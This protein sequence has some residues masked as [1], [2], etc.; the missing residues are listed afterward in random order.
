MRTVSY[1]M[2]IVV[3]ETTE[4]H[5][6]ARAAVAI[7]ATH[8]VPGPSRHVRQLLLL[9]EKRVEAPRA[10]L[11]GAARREPAEEIHVLSSGVDGRRKVRHAQ[12]HATGEGRPGA[13]GTMQRRASNVGVSAQPH[14]LERGDARGERAAPRQR[15]DARA[16]RR[17]QRRPQRRAA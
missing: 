5:D 13:A 1:G 9:F 7:G 10:R 14:A 11:H 17:E 16:G 2:R 3:P 4:H 12:R 8:A 15:A 6:V